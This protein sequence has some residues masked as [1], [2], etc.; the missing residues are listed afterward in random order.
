LRVRHG[1]RQDSKGF[2][3]LVD[4]LAAYEKLDPPTREGKVRIVKDIFDRKLVRLLVAEAHGALVGYALY[5][6][7]YS[8]FLALPTLYLE[9][10]F[11]LE[12]ERGKGAGKALF[13][14][15]VELARRDG[16]G[17]MEWSV[18]TWNRSA[19]GFYEKLGAKRMDDWY[20]Y[21]LDRRGLQS[22]TGD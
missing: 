19:I 18:L 21:R 6:Y 15:C 13:M 9:D 11:V 16:C 20:V 4:A 2:L 5:F 22:L 3:K 12:D 17:R 10:L 1:K 7:T 8:S 14:K